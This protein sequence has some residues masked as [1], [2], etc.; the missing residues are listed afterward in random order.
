MTREEALAYK[1]RWIAVNR[2]LIEEVRRASPEVKLRQLASLYDS[3][4]EFG[5]EEKLR[6]DEESV[7][8]KW[9]LLREH[10]AG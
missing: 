4:R 5:W 2:Y 3:V 6:D 8:R 7:W 9:Q 10:Y 1:N